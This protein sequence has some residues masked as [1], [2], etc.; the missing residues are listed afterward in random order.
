M[1]DPHQTMEDEEIN[2]HIPSSAP[3]ACSV[4]IVACTIL[5]KLHQTC[6]S[7]RKSLSSATAYRQKPAELLQTVKALDQKLHLLGMEIEH[8]LPIHTPL[9]PSRLPLSL[10]LTMALVIHFTYHSLLFDIHTTLTYPWSR[11][12][13]SLRQHP[14]FRAQ[15][16]S[17]YAVVAK[18]S[19]D[20]IL[21]SRHIP[22]DAACPFL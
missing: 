6:S 15:V 14:S 16:E 5:I 9:E 13:I 3:S 21:A 12:I 4:N 19:R 1:A 8:T 11:G 20:I 18:A 17:S 7:I 10:S 22:L 2:C